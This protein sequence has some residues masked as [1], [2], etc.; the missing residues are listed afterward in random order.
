MASLVFLFETTG[1]VV[2]TRLWRLAE[3]LASGLSFMNRR[4]SCPPIQSTTKRRCKFAG[5]QHAAELAVTNQRMALM[6]P[7]LPVTL[8][9]TALYTM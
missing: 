4:A 8:T 7:L 9:L 6:V 5:V 2:E 3:Y 1:R